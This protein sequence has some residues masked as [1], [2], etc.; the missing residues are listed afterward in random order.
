MLTWQHQ[1][2]SVDHYAVY[3]SLT[4]PYFAPGVASWLADRAT[5]TP[6]FTDDNPVTGADLTKAG[7]SYFYAVVPVN[8][9]GEAIGSANRT[10]AFVYGVV[11][12]TGP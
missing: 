5:S 2:T 4:A 8:A 10:G 1:A 9:S 12:G 3:R 6:T 7:V 11:P